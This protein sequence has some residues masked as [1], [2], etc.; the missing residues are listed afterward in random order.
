MHISSL[1][2]CCILQALLMDDVLDTGG[3]KKGSAPQQFEVAE[4]SFVLVLP[5][6]GSKAETADDTNK[7]C[8]CT[9]LGLQQTA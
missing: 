6:G 8:R 2:C 5:S 1:F 3:Y 7:W 4:G 9:A